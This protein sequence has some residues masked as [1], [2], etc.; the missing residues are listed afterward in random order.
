M[1]KPSESLVIYRLK[2]KS[3]DSFD[4]AI[5]T[6]R[7]GQ[8]MGRYLESLQTSL[9]LEQSEPNYPTI[10]PP[11]INICQDDLV[12]YIC[13]HEYTQGRQGSPITNIT[14][15]RMAETRPLF[16]YYHYYEPFLRGIFGTNADLTVT[17]EKHA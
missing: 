15:E 13:S 4:N 17:T 14:T 2:F 16:P 6:L 8:R 9:R 7:F 10:K 11:E 3:K 5:Q 1:E 12:I